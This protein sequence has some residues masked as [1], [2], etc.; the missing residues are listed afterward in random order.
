MV[1]VLTLPELFDLVALAKV[2]KADA[3][4]LLFLGGVT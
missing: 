3:A 2:L 4:A 1:S